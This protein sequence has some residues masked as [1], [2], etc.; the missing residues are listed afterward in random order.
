MKVVKADFLVSANTA[1]NY[2]EVDL[3]EIALAGRSN[4]GKSSAINVLT[5]RKGLA[6][7]SNTPGRTRLVN[8]FDVDVQLAKT[9]VVS[10]R[11]VDLPG[12]GFAKASRDERDEWRKR[13]DSY[14]TGR[15]S[16]RGVVHLLDIRH[17]PSDLDLQ[18]SEWLRALGRDEIAVFTKSDKLS[19]NERLTRMAAHEKAL[20]LPPRS[21]IAFSAQDGEGRDRLWNE[22]LDTL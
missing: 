20:G 8:F 5:G 11:L 3:P 12:Y 16:L 22:I 19:R 9:N 17:E 18:L 1:A 21:G 6:I 7:T 15:V 4:V 13:V 14:M 10:L 2:P